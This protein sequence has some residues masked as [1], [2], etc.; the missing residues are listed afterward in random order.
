MHRTI[1][2]HARWLRAK[3]EVSPSEPLLI[4]PICRVGYRLDMP[5]EETSAP[6]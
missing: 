6:R 4:Q 2:A 5:V 1:E 3:I